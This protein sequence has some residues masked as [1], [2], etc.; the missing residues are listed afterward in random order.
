M[1]LFFYSLYPHLYQKRR[2]S[3][4]RRKLINK[5]AFYLFDI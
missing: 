4:Q 3:T 5:N 2:K 1:I